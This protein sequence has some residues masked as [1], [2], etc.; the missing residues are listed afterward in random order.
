MKKLR[1]FLVV[2]TLNLVVILLSKLA[3]TNE[4]LCLSALINE[5]NN[6]EELIHAIK[7]NDSGKV[8]KL[9]DTGT[10]INQV[11]QLYIDT[12]RTPLGLAID[13]GH[14]EIIDLLLNYKQLNVN[15]SGTIKPPISLAL[16]KKRTDI[17]IRL[18]DHKRTRK[19]D[20]GDHFSTAIQIKYREGTR[21]L[22]DFIYG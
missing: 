14:M 8:S 11:L 12:A 7:E 19:S 17:I 9:L 22:I 20:F 2:I 6:S 13:L 1:T 15:D 16:L 21:L 4:I 18:M 10:D 3:S 5:R